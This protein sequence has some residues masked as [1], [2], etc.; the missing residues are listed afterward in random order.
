MGKL[1]KNAEKSREVE[2]HIILILSLH[3]LKNSLAF[4]L[5]PLAMHQIEKLFLQSAAMDAW[6]IHI[7]SAAL[8]LK[9]LPLLSLLI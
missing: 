8:L 6:N 5:F 4:S 2:D 7:R 3:S 1:C 9:K